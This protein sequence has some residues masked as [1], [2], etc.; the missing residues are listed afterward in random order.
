MTELIQLTDV[1]IAEVAGGQSISISTGQGNGS[2]VG[3][4]AGAGNSGAVS[5]G[6]AAGAEANNFAAALQTNAVVAANVFAVRRG[7]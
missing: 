2:G 4:G 3:Q 5:A 1:E 6:V 7:S